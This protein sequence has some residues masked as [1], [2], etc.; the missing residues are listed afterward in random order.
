MCF[1]DFPWNEYC[2]RNCDA[3][4]SAERI[5][6]VI[7]SGMEA[8]IPSSFSQPTTKKTWFT[9]AC[10]IAVRNKEEAYKRYKRLQ[11]NESRLLYVSARNRCKS[12]LRLA[13]NHFIH[14][15]CNELAN[16]S[17]SSSFWNL[18]KNLSNNFSSTSFPPLSNPDGSVAA[19]SSDKAELL[20][21]T[22]A[23]NSSLDD[24]GAV[25]PSPPSSHYV[26]PLIRISSKDVF[27]TLSGL[28]TSKAYGPDGIPPV[29]LTRIP[30]N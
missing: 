29:V 6:E 28:D 8:F 15:K 30:R 4:V 16:S 25:P 20:A 14:T 13:K 17:S 24:S 27:S 9:H 18:A 11:T 22:F 3:S 2:F 12:V 26:M 1:V 19:S 23:S 10:S 5:T 7:L 21:N